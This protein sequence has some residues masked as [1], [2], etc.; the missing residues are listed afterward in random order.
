MH[1]G[2]WHGHFTCDIGMPMFSFFQYGSGGGNGNGVPPAADGTDASEADSWAQTDGT[3][4][5]LEIQLEPVT[6]EV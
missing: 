5:S 1:A 4:G 2:F 6:A 3:I